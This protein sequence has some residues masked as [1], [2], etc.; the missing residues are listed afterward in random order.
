MK[1]IS[2]LLGL[3]LILIGESAFGKTLPDSA[4]WVTSSKLLKMDDNL[5]V[6]MEIEISRHLRTNE[7]VKLIPC[8]DDDEGNH[9]ELPP[10]YVN[11]R[12]LHLMFLREAKKHKEDYVAMKRNNRQK[13]A[14][15]YLRAIPFATWMRQAVLSLTEEACG[16]GVYRRK[17]TTELAH[18]HE[19]PQKKPLLA[20]VIPQ[21]EERK[22]R[23]ESGSAFLDFPLDKTEI[24]PEYRN[25]SA[26]LEKIERSIN[27]IRNDSNAAITR[28]IIHGYASPEGPFDNNERLACERTNTLKKHVM[29]LYTLPDS[30]FSITHTAEDWEGFIR[31][32]RADTILA[33]REAL[34]RIA[35]SRLSP[36]SKEEKMRKRHAA[37]FAFLLKQCFAELRHSDYTIRYAVR[38]FTVEQAKEV[39]RTNPK[40]LS[41]GEMFRIA[42][43]YS[44]GSEAYKELFMTAVRLNPDDPVANLN[45]A[46]IVLA[47][48]DADGAE[49]YLEKGL[50]CTEKILATGVWYMLKG[51]YEEAAAWLQEAEAEGLEEATENLKQ[52]RELY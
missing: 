42:Q 29:Q 39:Y 37:S 31:I 28:I 41:I 7:S 51:K 49:P 25:N 35:E 3:T 20:F 26:E 8:L 23:E 22:I 2:V 15:R 47:Q 10:I 27:L 40:N 46:C 45:A 16:C 9:A 11:G 5:V 33:D 36:D 17:G 38:P 19:L 14:V 4:L 1:P 50:D 21:V 30:L 24:Y 6:S 52:I 13:Q 48:G 34:L 43:T 44:P 18:L 12:N 32:L